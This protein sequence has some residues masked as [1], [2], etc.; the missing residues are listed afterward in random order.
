MSYNKI[1]DFDSSYGNPYWIAQNPNTGLLYGIYTKTPSIPGGNYIYELDYNGGSPS[2]LTPELANLS[3]NIY[4]TGIPCFDNISGT[5]WMYF[6][7]K[8]SV[9]GD[10]RWEYLNLSTNSLFSDSITSSGGLSIGAQGESYGSM[11][12]PSWDTFSYG[13]VEYSNT[14]T[15]GGVIFNA[16]FTSGRNLV[17]RLDS[18]TKKFYAGLTEGPTNILYGWYKD[19]SPAGNYIFS[20]NV[21]TS[22]FTDLGNFSNNIQGDLAYYS[23]TNSLYGVR[24]QSSNLQLFRFN[25]NTNATSVITTHIN[26]SA[27]NYTG[28]VIIIDD[29]AYYLGSN[30]GN[31]YSW[32]LVAGS[33]ATEHTFGSAGDGSGPVN[34]LFSASTSPANVLLGVTLYGGSNP[35]YGT[36]YSLSLPVPPTPIPCAET[37]YCVDLTNSSLYT[38]SDIYENTG[39]Y[40]GIY[41]YFTGQTTGNYIYYS[42]SSDSWCLSTTLG[43]SCVMFGRTPCLSTCP[44]LDGSFFNSGICPTPTPTLTPQCQLDFSSIF[45]CNVVPTPT[46]TLTTTT[47]PTTT[48]TITPTNPCPVNA[49]VSINLITPNQTPTPTQTPTLTPTGYCDNIVGVAYSTMLS[50][51]VICNEVNMYELCQTS[52]STPVYY[53]SSAGALHNG[54]GATL[55]SYY[56]SYI[57][58]SSTTTCLKYLGVV[59]NVGNESSITLIDGPFSDCTICFPSP[60]PTKT[61][62]MTPTM[63]VTITPSPTITKTPFASPSPTPSLSSSYQT[64]HVYKLCLNDTYV[65]DNVNP[66]YKV[67]T[68]PLNDGDVFGATF[69][70][71]NVPIQYNCW[72][73]LGNYIGTISGVVSGGGQPYRG[74]ISGGTIPITYSGDWFISNPV[75]DTEQNIV[76]PDCGDCGGTP[77]HQ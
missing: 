39:L 68:S 36:I 44:D 52:S 38:F 61:P 17:Y 77:N 16:S 4:N 10:L 31:L 32:D 57:D 24:K 28:G 42:N 7:A 33:G 51:T 15:N 58:A 20:Y 55:D 8:N 69:N 46:P 35:P 25:L 26:E 6:V 56:T 45:D 72:T 54:T 66:P 40:Y 47:T 18:S 67:D 3:T 13:T 53:Y 1:Y 59:S 76:F 50:G 49:D 65:V 27:T 62:T 64:W 41:N 73:Y 21:S 63:T 9:T 37:Y 70:K 29:V 22:A 14:G 75:W 43:G 74:L 2:V 71:N 48:P 60:T 30:L 19:T 11:I 23:T 34:R 12:H 5:D